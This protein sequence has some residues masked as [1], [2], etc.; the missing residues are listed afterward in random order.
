V[1]ARA[2]LS[3]EFV[4]KTKRVPMMDAAAQLVCHK[5]LDQTRISNVTAAAKVGR[6]TFYLA[7]AGREHCFEQ[8]LTWIGESSREAIAVASDPG[9]GGL[10]DFAAEH[11][12]R[13]AF[14]LEHGPKVSLS[15]WQSEQESL[16]GLIDPHLGLSESARLMVAGGLSELLRRHLAH[17][18]AVDP[19]SLSGDRK[20][21]V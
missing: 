4:A 15:I 11:P 7:F 9:L 2:R 21:V 17:Q 8:A 12:H 16:A 13:A 3:K 1:R 5:G 19:R 20:S 6:E 14:Y 18:P 10:L